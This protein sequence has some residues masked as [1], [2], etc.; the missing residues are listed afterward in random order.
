M[1]IFDGYLICSDMDGT[2]MGNP[3]AVAKNRD[4]VKY[5]TDNGGFFTFATGRMVG[6]LYDTDLVG[7]INSPAA[8]S[9]GALIYDYTRERIVRESR[10]EFS[11]RE[12]VSAIEHIMPDGSSIQLYGISC[13]KVG[14]SEIMSIGD[15]KDLCEKDS[16]I[17]DARALKVLCRFGNA[18]D[19]DE[20]KSAALSLPFFSDSYI[21][22]S[23]PLGVEFNSVDGTKGA[24]I[25]Y[26]KKN[27]PGVKVTVAVGDYENDISMIK[28]ADIGAAPANAIDQIKKIVDIE[29]A[30]VSDGAVS[31]LIYRLEKMIKDGE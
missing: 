9:N 24:A 16:A 10:L 22:K 23:W 15:C 21:S 17:A 4:A 29:V 2:F 25:E 18:A 3:D 19:A 27:I 31:D 1:G 20:F 5:F 13:D 8:L 6:H 12:F 28:S 14:V 7:I 26:M 11:V 30:H